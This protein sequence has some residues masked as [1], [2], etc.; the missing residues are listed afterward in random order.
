MA[1][2]HLEYNSA[3]CFED[4]C[5]RISN[6]VGLEL[7]LNESLVAIS[8]LHEAVHSSPIPCCW[9]GYSKRIYSCYYF[10]FLQ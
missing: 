5:S 3:V 1:I 9:N 8:P 4:S 7:R 10:S 6:H 2:F